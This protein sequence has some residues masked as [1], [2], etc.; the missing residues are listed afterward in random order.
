MVAPLDVAPMLRGIR[1]AGDLGGV[2]R[3]RLGL[4]VRTFGVAAGDLGLG[5]EL[6]GIIGRLT[7]G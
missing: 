5:L 1:L 2:Q 3:G 6:D 7:G 4:G